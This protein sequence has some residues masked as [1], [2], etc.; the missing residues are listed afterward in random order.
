MP[1]A[2]WLS[3]A[4]I[5]SLL[6][7]SPPDHPSLHAP[8]QASLPHST[9]RWPFQCPLEHLPG[10]QL[11]WDCLHLC[12]C[13]PKWEGTVCIS[14]SLLHLGKYQACTLNA[15]PRKKGL[16]LPIW[17]T[18]GVSPPLLLQIMWQCPFPLT[19][20]WGWDR[21]SFSYTD[22][23]WIPPPSFLWVI[24]ISFPL[25]LSSKGNTH[26][27]LYT[28]IWDNTS[29][30]RL[31]PLPLP[32]SVT[33]SIEESLWAGDGGVIPSAIHIAQVCNLDVQYLVRMGGVGDRMA[34]ITEFVI[35]WLKVRSVLLLKFYLL[36]WR[37]KIIQ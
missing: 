18:K 31:L 25:F 35:R 20:L 29:S 15:A 1:T 9:G 26:N 19:H 28:H 17:T 33:H 7:P 24:Q 16:P 8:L 12:Y 21:Y 6:F 27:L 23:I 32:P 34:A 11:P 2:S 37:G 14:T 13:L 4:A 36:N 22:S 3:D 10:V 5:G 30:P